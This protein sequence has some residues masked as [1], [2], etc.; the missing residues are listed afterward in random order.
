[1]VL[2]GNTSALSPDLPGASNPIN[3]GLSSSLYLCAQFCLQMPTCALV[4]PPHPS[5]FLLHFQP[6]RIVKMSP[7]EQRSRGHAGVTHFTSLSP[8]PGS[9]PFVCSCVWSTQAGAWLRAQA[10]S[11]LLCPAHSTALLL[12]AGDER[13]PLLP[14]CHFSRCLKSKRQERGQPVLLS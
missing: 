12:R 3:S 13:G 4:S 8:S 11:P 7:I 2:L 5:L 1:M 14:A 6:I 9:S 10:T